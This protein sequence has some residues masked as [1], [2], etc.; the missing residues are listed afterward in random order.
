MT[1]AI[2]KPANVTD[3]GDHTVTDMGTIKIGRSNYKIEQVDYEATETHDEQTWLQLIGPRGTAYVLNE[4]LMQTG[5]FTPVSLFSGPMIRKGNRVE[6][7]ILGSII[8]RVK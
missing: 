2:M 3:H 6:F 8:E 7:I 1:T 5:R 4:D